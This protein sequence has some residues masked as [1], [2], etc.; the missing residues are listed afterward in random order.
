M[1]FT[2]HVVGHGGVGTA[3]PKLLFCPQNSHPISPPFQMWLAT[4]L[5]LQYFNLCRSSCVFRPTFCLSSRQTF[6]FKRQ[7]GTLTLTEL[8]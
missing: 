3:A 2:T 5:I 1:I 8:F 7:N 6:V 4:F